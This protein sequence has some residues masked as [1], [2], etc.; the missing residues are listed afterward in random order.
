MTNAFELLATPTPP[1][2]PADAERV[3]WEAYGIEGN[4]RRLAGE[5]D[6]NFCIGSAEGPFTLKIANRAEESLDVVAAAL[7]HIARVAPDLPVPRV[8]RTRENGRVGRV[9]L[10]GRQHP[11]GVGDWEG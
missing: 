3:A 2:E 6:A 7:E 1:A 5:R 10:G 4:A 11:G 9:Q 8:R